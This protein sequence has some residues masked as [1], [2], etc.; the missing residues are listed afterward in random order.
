MQ[1][2]DG[3][4][5]GLAF[6]GVPGGHEFTSFVLGLYN[7]AGTGQQLPTDVLD[8]IKTILTQMKMMYRSVVIED[9]MNVA[10]DE[11]RSRTSKI[12]ALSNKIGSL[13]M[14]HFI[15][16]LLDNFGEDVAIKLQ[17]VGKKIFNKYNLKVR[18]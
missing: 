1:S 7:A 11:V 8:K 2:K 5:T 13:N 17:S 12:G 10:I 18:I 6:H 15:S 16:D 14:Y 4:D 3:N 9:G